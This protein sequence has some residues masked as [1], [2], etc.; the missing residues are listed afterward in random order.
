MFKTMLS[1]EGIYYVPN[2][3]RVIQRCLKCKGFRI[4][5]FPLYY[6]KLHKE[7]HLHSRFDN[8]DNIECP[9]LLQ[10]VYWTILPTIKQ[11]N[12]QIRI[13]IPLNSSV[14]I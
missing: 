7:A 14:Y 8:S 2:L 1:F 10:A 9:H 5:S 13:G 11:L 12:A 4:Q 3:S 6:C